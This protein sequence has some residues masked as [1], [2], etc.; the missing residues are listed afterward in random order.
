MCSEMDHQVVGFFGC[1]QAIMTLVLFGGFPNS[2]SPVGGLFYFHAFHIALVRCSFDCASMSTTRWRMISGTLFDVSDIA[3]VA[4]LRR[5]KRDGASTLS[6]W[7]GDALRGLGAW[8]TGGGEGGRGGWLS[9][10]F[11]WSWP[12]V[13]ASMNC[14]ASWCFCCSCC[15]RVSRGYLRVYSCCK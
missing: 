13:S 2:S 6:T 3:D 7:T 8:N 14:S 11:S 5:S 10:W 4:K 12:V 9:K 15:Y 1:V